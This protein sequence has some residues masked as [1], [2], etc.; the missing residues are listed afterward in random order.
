[1]SESRLVFLMECYAGMQECADAH[2]HNRALIAY[3]AYLGVI[4]CRRHVSDFVS[5]RDRDGFLEDLLETVL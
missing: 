3:A 2:S 4:M 5:A 1:M